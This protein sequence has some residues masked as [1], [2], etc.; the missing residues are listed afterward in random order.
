MR[1]EGVRMDGNWMDGWKSSCDASHI[2]AFIVH[3]AAS[4]SASA[5]V[6]SY[7]LQLDSMSGIASRADPSTIDACDRG[8]NFRTLDF[9]LWT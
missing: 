9:G 6:I 3:H 7:K 8:P 2:T 4:T 5:L 1:D